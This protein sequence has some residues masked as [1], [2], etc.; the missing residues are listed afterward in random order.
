MTRVAEATGLSRATLRAGLRELDAPLPGDGRRGTRERLRRPGGGRRPLLESDAQL[1]RGWERGGA[2][3]TR[4][5]PRSPL[6]WTWKSAARVAA[7]LQSQGQAVSERR[8]NRLRPELGYSLPSNRTTLA[9]CP[10]PDREAQFQSLN[11]RVK[12]V[13]R[14]GQ[15][16]VSVDTK[17]K[18]LGGQWRNGGWEGQPLGPPEKVKGPDFPDAEVG[19]VLPDGVSDRAT[20]PGGGRVGGE[21]ATAEFA[22]E[23]AAAGGA[24]QGPRRLSPSP[25]PAAHG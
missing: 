25:A 10:P 8:V 5:D 6:R 15:P 1:L 21:H 17:K 22:V 18:D 7:E 20:N 3:V 24:P 23:T 19:K 16:V 9:G 14:Q 4:G 2:P 12:A 11:R 13:Q